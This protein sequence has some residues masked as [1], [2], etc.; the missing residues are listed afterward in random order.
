MLRRNEDRKWTKLPVGD[1]SNVPEGSPLA[2]DSTGLPKIFTSIPNAFKCEAAE[3]PYGPAPTIAIRQ[4]VDCSM[5]ILSLPFQWRTVVRH[6]YTFAINH[7]SDLVPIEPG[8]TFFRDFRARSAPPRRN[9]GRLPNRYVEC[10]GALTLL[11][12]APVCAAYPRQI[13]AG[14]RPA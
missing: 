4:S 12:A 9:K 13:Y 8:G 10:S 6:N 11:N 2:Q 14:G 7:T 5:T 1:R 3:S